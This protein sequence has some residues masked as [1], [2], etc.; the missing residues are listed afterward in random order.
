M[1]LVGPAGSSREFT[2]FSWSDFV[3]T[4]EAPTMHPFMLLKE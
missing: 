4:G 1:V 3:A 2:T